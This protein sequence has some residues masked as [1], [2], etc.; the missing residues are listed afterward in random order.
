MGGVEF[1]DKSGQPRSDEEI[2]EALAE[3][4]KQ[5]V[6][7]IGKIPPSTLII[8]PIAV[9][10]LRELLTIR[11]IIRKKAENGNRNNTNHTSP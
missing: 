7:G 4:Q 6:T 3:L 8:L 2:N 1:H 5:L 10:S 11:N 9:Q